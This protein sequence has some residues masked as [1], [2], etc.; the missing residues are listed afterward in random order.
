AKNIT[1][2]GTGSFGG[3]ITAGGNINAAKEV[4][5]HNGYG[6]TITLGGDNAGND[7]E[8]RLSNGGRPLSIYSPNA[9][10]YTTVLQV[11]KNARIQQRL[12]TNDLDP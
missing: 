5:A 4:I 8:I 1:A 2:S 3:N 9:A 6:D 10:N 11:W 7:Y 12:A